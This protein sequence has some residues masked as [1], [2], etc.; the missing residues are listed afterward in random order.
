MPHRNFP[1][2]VPSTQREFTQSKYR[3]AA[4]FD[5][6]IVQFLSIDERCVNPPSLSVITYQTTLNFPGCWTFDIGAECRLSRCSIVD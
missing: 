1:N 5:P 3:A 4:H 6:H 2:C